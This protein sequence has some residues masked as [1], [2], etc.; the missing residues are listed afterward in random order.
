M[1]N[2]SAREAHG[3]AVC[4]GPSGLR[5]LSPAM[6]EADKLARG[7]TGQPEGQ[8][9]QK[10]GQVLA[11]FKA[12]AP[13]MGFGPRI[14]HAIDWLFT[15]TRP[16]DWVE[17]S[18]PIVWPSAALQRQALDLGV[19][20]AKALNRLL[21][22]TGLVVMR[23][24]PNGKRYGKRGADGRIIEAYG[25]DLTPLAARQAE[26][27]A[28]A[29]AGRAEQERVHQ[30]HRRATIARNGLAQIMETADELGFTDPARQRLAEEARGLGR[31]L[32]KLEGGPELEFGVA[33][34]ERRQL[35]AREWLESLLPQAAQEAL[36]SVD[37]DPKGPEYRPHQYTYKPTDPTKDTVAAPEESSSQAD[38]AVPDQVPPVMQQSEQADRTERAARTDNRTVLRINTDEL[39]TL[40]P[41]LRPY[42]RTSAPC[43]PDIVDA[44]GFLRHD[45]G[46]S[47]PLW[48]EAC[49]AMGREEAAIALAIVSTK[50][51]GHFTSSPG[52]Y[53]HGMVAKAKAGELNLTR[54]IW[55]LRSRA[56][57]I[58]GRPKRL[59]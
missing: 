51:A 4:K 30:L 10:P 53:F 59:Q 50:P 29:A 41:R 57:T 56:G 27:E 15:F 32:T 28:A 11:A 17:G 34:L 24:S 40:A 58:E 35:E 7:F 45:L 44:A 49:G 48:G 9:G 13:H 22:E 8:G 21:V 19:S 33:S 39:I 55:G 18:H 3:R 43:W 54:T 47:Q 6:L 16:Q 37:S 26:F 1:E 46:I 38:Q 52:G 12:A 20:Q 5:R 36:E 42:L 14:V 31:A 23:D 2:E 25:F